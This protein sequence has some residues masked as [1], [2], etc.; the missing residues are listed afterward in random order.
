MTTET[1][2]PSGADDGVPVCARHRDRETGVRCQRCNSPI[3]F[4]CMVPA[5]VGFQC[6]SCVTTAAAK[7]R[8][9]LVL[10]GL[11]TPYVTYF[12]LAVNVAVAVAGLATSAWAEGEL[13][14]IGIRGGLIGGGVDFDGQRF[15]FIGVDEGEWYRVVT[16]AFIHA[17]PIHLAFNMF[18]LWQIGTLLESALGRLRFALL[19]A[20]AVLG[21]SFGALLVAPDIIT[22]GASGGVFGLM[23]AFYVAERNGRFGARRSAVGLFIAINLVLTFAVPGISIGGHLGGL[24]AGAAIGWAFTEFDRRSLSQ[25]APIALAL[26]SCVTLFAGSLWAASL[27]M[28][29]LF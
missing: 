12:L 15:E 28:T 17:G 2:G 18:M 26:A 11:A 4:Q 3:C 24:A 21:G 20:V 10:A 29:P 14:T 8:Q 27:W 23:G 16:G 13:G 9:P 19:Y 22:V 7:T 6:E 25:A 5:S 1:V